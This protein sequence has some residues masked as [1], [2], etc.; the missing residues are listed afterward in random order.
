MPVLKGFNFVF[1]DVRAKD[2]FYQVR[3]ALPIKEFISLMLIGI[4]HFRSPH[5]IA[6]LISFSV[7]SMT[8]IPDTEIYRKFYS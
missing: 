4:E 7:K 1:F 2:V 8:I 3:A 5:V 6:V